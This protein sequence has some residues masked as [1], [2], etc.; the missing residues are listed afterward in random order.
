[1]KNFI[2]NNKFILIA[3]A[4]LIICFV[5]PE[6]KSSVLLALKGLSL[7]LSLKKDKDLEVALIDFVILILESF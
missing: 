5:F 3:V 1:M 4:I 2:K 6:I 7:V